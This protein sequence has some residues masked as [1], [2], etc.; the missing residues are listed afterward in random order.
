MYEIDGLLRGLYRDLDKSL[1]P[2]E[3][4][5][6]NGARHEALALQEH[7]EFV[8]AAMLIIYEKKKLLLLDPSK[9]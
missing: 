2:F 3:I 1:T 6:A 8:C 4:A 9:P 7:I 5:I